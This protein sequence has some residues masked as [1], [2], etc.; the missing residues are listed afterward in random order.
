MSKDYE[1]QSD[2]HLVQR[3]Q[4]G[5]EEAGNTLCQ[6][7]LSVLQRFFKRK[8]RNPE[9]A[10]DLTQ[11]T[12]LAALDSLKKGQ[13]PRVFRSWLYGIATHV[14]ARWIQKKQKQDPQVV[15]DITAEDESRHISLVELLLAPVT[16]QPEHGVIDNDIGNI[17]RRFEKTLRPEELAV[18]QL[19][20]NSSPTFKAIGKELGIKPNTAKVRYHRA[21]K[22]FR[23][24]LKRRYPDIYHSLIGG[25]E[26]LDK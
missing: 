24:W 1:E 18:F 7:Y 6:R 3:Y 10:E 21:V 13:S 25:G 23:A 11:E 16:D 5:D 19:R 22:E 20:L 15:L 4:N 2:A 26:E 9:D 12:F 14:I 17:R 8:I